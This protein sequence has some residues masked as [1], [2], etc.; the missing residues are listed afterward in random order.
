MGKVDLRIGEEVH[1]HGPVA[2]DKV[3]H[4]VEASFLRVPRR[5]VLVEEVAAKKQQ[6]DILV[7]GKIVKKIFRC[8]WLTVKS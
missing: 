5:L 3:L 7:G 6:V 8:N 1:L 2:Q 4:E